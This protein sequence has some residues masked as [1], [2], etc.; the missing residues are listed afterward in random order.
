[1]SWHCPYLTTAEEGAA[2][3]RTMT[4][5]FLITLQPTGVDL[6]DGPAALVA[7]TE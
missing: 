7:E 3:V 6:A 4:A 1:M 5:G 2:G